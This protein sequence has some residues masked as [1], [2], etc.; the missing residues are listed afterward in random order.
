MVVLA[1]RVKV[2]TATT[3]TGTITLGAAEAGYQTFAGGG[4]SN[5][6]IVRYVIEDGTNN[7]EIGTGT[8]TASGTTLSRTVT[9]SSNSGSALNLSGS[10][11]VFLSPAAQDFN[12]TLTLSGDVTGSATLTDLGDA[13][14]TAT[15][16]DDSHNHVIA[17]V[18]GLQS[19]LDA[20]A[21]VAGTLTKS[22]VSGESSTISLSSSITPTPIVSATK[23]VPQAG[24]SSKGSWDV[25]SNGA[26]YDRLNSAYNTTLTPSSSTL[27]LGSGSFSSADIGKTIEG[28][29]GVAVLT[30]T[31]G[32]Y[33]EITPFN[34]NTAISSGSWSMNSAIVDAA[35]GIKLSSGLTG[36]WEV[37]NLS[38]NQNYYIGSTA[39]FPRSVFF[40][41]D[42][43]R[44][45]VVC[46]STDRVQKWD[47]S[48]AW[49]ITS[50]SNWDF[51]GI[52]SQD[53]DPRGLFFKPD[54]LA[55]YLAGNQYNK[56]YKYDLSTAWDISTLSHNSSDVFD[57][58]S[59]ETFPESV[60]FKPDG[61][62]MY[63]IG[64]SDDRV[65]EY[66]LSTAWDVTS[67]S[68]LQ[69]FRVDLSSG[70][71]EYFPTDVVFKP[72]G[73][74]MYVCGAFNDKVFE[75]D[76]STAWDITSASLTDSISI[77]GQENNPQGI[78]FREDGA[79]MYLTGSSS[80]N[81]NEYDMGTT[82]S[83]TGYI[84]S[85]TNAGGQ[86]DTEYWT[87]INSMTADDIAGA[88]AAY[89]AVSTDDRTTWS[90][91][92][93]SNGVRPIVRNNSGTWQY[94]SNASYASQT[95]ANS[96]TNSELYALQ[97]ALTDVSIN[98][99]DKTQLE[100]VTDPNHYTL[101]DSLD[102]MIGLY[103]GSASVDVPSSDGVS[104]NYDAASIIQGAV[105]GTDYNY[106]FPAANKVRITSLATH[107]LKVRV[108]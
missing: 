87:D 12:Q 54:G 69:F 79:K 93:N 50:A 53:D 52:S 105:L 28:N 31:N 3:G 20:A 30:A 55:M 51:F 64:D 73:L 41:P 2:A 82:V 90:V 34:D 48:T 65:F 102:L 25:A 91:I 106:D 84:P 43:T 107:N 26:N 21:S 86:I 14:I 61:T 9:E 35:N 60:F 103:L 74:K 15:V 80:D 99:M 27:S 97:Q 19:Q 77:V 108:I 76:L 13:T 49:D 75:Y 40:K 62:K 83:A 22:F 92:H 17:N 68:Y 39:T 18:D 10:A 37:A 11:V 70:G 36:I 66:D 16:V 5:G 24:I 104:I 44:V 81:I 4:V 94:N 96:T 67:A 46:S 32:S 29:G 45:F 1:N 42:G 56:I 57:V 85:I 38:Y 78:Y 100:A 98:R 6:D 88:G 95:W 33:V 47:L 23:E 101:G 89:Y 71:S 72:D 63:I 58:S 8:Y 7:W 59:Q